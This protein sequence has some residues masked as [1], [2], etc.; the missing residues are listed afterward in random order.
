VIASWRIRSCCWWAAIRVITGCPDLRPTCW[1]T[2]FLAG[3][4]PCNLMFARSGSGSG[5]REQCCLWQTRHHG[6]SLHVYRG[7]GHVAQRLPRQLE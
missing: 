7:H 4:G 6:S 1:H 5:R 2:V 3:T